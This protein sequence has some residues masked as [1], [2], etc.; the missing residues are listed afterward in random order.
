MDNAVSFPGVKPTRC[1]ADHST[2]IEPRLKKRFELCFYLS[3]WTFMASSRL[4][5]ATARI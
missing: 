1:D 5:F 3:L 2:V 4:K